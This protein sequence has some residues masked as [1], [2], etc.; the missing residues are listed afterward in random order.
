M[1]NPNPK[2]VAFD[3]V[4]LLTDSEKTTNFTLEMLEGGCI[5]ASYHLSIGDCG[6]LVE[7]LR[8]TAR[9]PRDAMVV[10]VALDN[11]KQT[12]CMRR[13]GAI[14]ALWCAEEDGCFRL[15]LHMATKLACDLEQTADEARD[16]LEKVSKKAA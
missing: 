4:I 13:E 7:F 2:R 14:V 11:G 5:C 1:T 6:P 16:H 10:G 15:S 8:D 12:I 9:G 3:I